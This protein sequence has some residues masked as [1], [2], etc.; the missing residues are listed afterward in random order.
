MNTE[1]LLTEAWQN[2]NAAIGALWDL[3]KTD[4]LWLE[5]A[6]S[7]EPAE[8]FEVF[9]DHKHPTMQLLATTF[10]Q[11]RA[12]L[13]HL[14]IACTD[15]DAKLRAQARAMHPAKRCEALRRVLRRHHADQR[16]NW[17]ALSAHEDALTRRLVARHATGLALEDLA[18]DPDHLVRR[19]ALARLG[20]T[21]RGVDSRANAKH[22]EAVKVA[23]GE[24]LNALVKSTDNYVRKQ[25]ARKATDRRTLVR[26]LGDK[27]G[28]VTSA[29]LARM[30]AL[31]LAT[32]EL[33]IDLEIALMRCCS[34]WGGAHPGWTALVYKCGGER[35]FRAAARHCCLTNVRRYVAENTI[36]PKTR[37]LARAACSAPPVKFRATAY[38]P[39]QSPARGEVRDWSRRSAPFLTQAD[40]QSDDRIV[41]RNAIAYVD[42][43]HALRAMLTDSSPAVVRAALG[44]LHG[45][46][47]VA[48]P[49]DTRTARLVVRATRKWG[50]T[51]PDWP[52]LRGAHP[53]VDRVIARRGPADATQT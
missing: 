9:A 11:T 39:K 24:Q 7:T 15:H 14:L 12:A 4:T 43:P 20:R 42:D 53:S 35:I 45:L 22:R 33:T 6:T 38:L 19:A 25:V 17:A 23:A 29:A 49:L 51:H 28:P 50:D 8:Y 30:Q 21:K 47:Y 32:P 37:V 31:K 3:A 44:R 18:D 41:R 52:V 16:I 1:E 40:L 48:G 2:S 36:R 26:L 27:H 34:N 5:L 13:E 46:G 10:A